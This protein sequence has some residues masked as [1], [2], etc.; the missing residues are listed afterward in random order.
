VRVQIGR[1]ENSHAEAG[2]ASRKRARA[3]RISLR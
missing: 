2:V 3:V 1:G